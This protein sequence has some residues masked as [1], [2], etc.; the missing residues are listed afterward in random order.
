MN[1]VKF[2]DVKWVTSHVQLVGCY[3]WTWSQVYLK[4]KL[5][6]LTLLLLTITRKNWLVPILS[7]W[8]V[9][10]LPALD[11]WLWT[12]YTWIFYFLSTKNVESNIKHDTFEQNWCCFTCSLSSFQISNSNKKA[13]WN[14]ENGVT[15][16]TYQGVHFHQL[17]CYA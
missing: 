11:F 8:N 7:L 12:F 4:Q 3:V 5:M 6:I 9:V 2:R 15:S 13:E 10:I 17:V 1:K 16:V 14:F